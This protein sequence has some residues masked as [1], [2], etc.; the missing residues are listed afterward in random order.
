[1]LIMNYIKKIKSI[2]FKRIPNIVV[3]DYNLGSGIKELFGMYIWDWG[4]LHWKIK[5]VIEVYQFI[6]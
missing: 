1:M 3:L 4:K 2:G 5:R 6:P